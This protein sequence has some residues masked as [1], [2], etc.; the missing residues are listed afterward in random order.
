VR[1]LR[2]V[3][4]A[5]DFEVAHPSRSAR[6][7]L[8]SLADEAQGGRKRGLA[9]MAL[10]SAK[11]SKGWRSARTGVSLP[12]MRSA[13][14]RFAPTSNALYRTPR[15]QAIFDSSGFR[16]LTFWLSGISERGARTIGAEQH[17]FAA[18]SAPRRKLPTHP[19][20]S[21]NGMVTVSAPICRLQFAAAGLAEIAQRFHL[22]DQVGQIDECPVWG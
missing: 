15:V 1:L 9:R 4:S 11:A 20:Y 16:I 19:K 17:Q 14:R 13:R 21:N 6:P 10:I 22:V 7:P 12:P 5:R 8:R 18:K 3:I 2:A